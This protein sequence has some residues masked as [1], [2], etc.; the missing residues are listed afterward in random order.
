MKIAATY[1]PNNMIFFLAHQKR[2]ASVQEKISLE[3]QNKNAPYFVQ[4]C[5]T[6]LLCCVAV[7][8]E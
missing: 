3:M 8:M 5:A 1:I 4:G 7:F 2:R 6:C